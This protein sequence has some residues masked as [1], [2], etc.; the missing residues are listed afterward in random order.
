MWNQQLKSKMKGRIQGSKSSLE[1][2]LGLMANY[3][4]V[5][6]TSEL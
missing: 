1:D 4:A 5:K 2:I 3:R 6:Q